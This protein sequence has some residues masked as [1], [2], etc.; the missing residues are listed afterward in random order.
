M[1]RPKPDIIFR[2]DSGIETLEVLAS[3]GMWFVC[4]QDQPIGLVKKSWTS[5][6]ET[7]KYPRTGF[8]NPAHAF[9]LAERLNERFMTDQFTVMEIK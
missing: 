8:N 5:R 4:Y 3:P 2:D 9:K 1:A 7:V 6:G